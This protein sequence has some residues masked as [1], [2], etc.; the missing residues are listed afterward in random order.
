MSQEREAEDNEA[1]PESR[2]KFE[3][4]FEHANDAIFIVDVENDS[5]ADC[6]PAAEELVEYS[7]EELLTMPASDLHPHN[8]DL[9]MDFADTVIDQGEG[10][11][12]DITCYCKSGD[13]IPAEMSASV[14]ELDGRPHIVNH[15]RETTDREERDWFEALLEHSSDLITVVKHDGS[16]RYQSASVDNVL[17][18]SPAE[19]RDETYFEFLH[20]DDETE[21]RQVLETLV[22]QSGGAVMRR[23]YRFRRADGTWAWLEAI[24]SHRPE[25][26]ISGYVINARDITA[27]KESQQQAMVLNRVLRHNLRND[28]NVIQGRAEILADVDQEEVV[29]NAETIASNAGNLLDLTSYTQDLSDMIGSHHV[30]QH[31]L[32]LARLIE[33]EVT[34]IRE[35]YPRATIEVAASADYTVRAAPNLELAVTHVLTNAIE[36]NDIDTTR[37]EITVRSSTDRE[38]YIDL[39]IADN[40]PGIPEEERAVLLEGN[41]EPL[42]HGSGIGLW[43]V[44]WI[45][46]RSGGYLTFDENDPRGSQVTMAVPAAESEPNR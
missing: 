9:F 40:G 31:R 44:N 3:T 7:R 12:D 1:L 34:T 11:T 30:T 20:P 27:R 14:I 15:I 22:D 26:T 33:Q 19:L 6:N 28:L 42:R 46:S 39:V 38:G 16:I 23:E 25:T 41:E 8:L 2:R 45:I 24:A 21:I 18:Y 29:E 4:V 35:R 37:V 13:I 36:H 17:G 5:I 43:L 10:R 32:D